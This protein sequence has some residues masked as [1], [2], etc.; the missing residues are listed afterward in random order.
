MAEMEP[1][2]TADVVAGPTAALV[3]VVLDGLV[4]CA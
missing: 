2:D 4:V 3:V 1:G